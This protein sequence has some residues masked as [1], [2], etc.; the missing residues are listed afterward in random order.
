MKYDVVLMNPPFGKIISDESTKTYLKANYQNYWTDYYNLFIYRGKELS[1]YGVLGAIVPNR[2]LYAKKSAAIRELLTSKWPIRTLIEFGRD[3]MDSAA[4]D[5]MVFTVMEIEEYENPQYCFTSNLTN[6]DPELRSNELI[7]WVKSPRPIIR[8]DYFSEIQG[9]PLAYNAPSD[10]LKLFKS[11]RSLEPIYATVATGGKTFNDERFLRLRWEVQPETLSDSWIS[12]DTGGDYQPFVSPSPFTQLWK[13]DGYEVRNFGIQRHGT[14]AQVMQSSKFWFHSAL[15]YPLTSSIGF[16]PRV[17]PEMTIL[18][19]DSIGIIP[20]DDN[21][22]AKLSLLGLLNSSWAEEILTCFGEHRRNENSTVKN[23]PVFLDDEDLENKLA[24]LALKCIKEILIWETH[25][26]ESAIFVSPMFENEIPNISKSL[27]ELITK[28][29]SIAYKGFH[30]S[31]KYKQTQNNVSRI[32]AFIKPSIPSERVVDL[33]S[34]YFGCIFGRW[35]ILYSIGNKPMPNLPDPFTTLPICPPG[36]LQN[37]KGLPASP[38]DV[39][40]N[41]PLRISWSGILVDDEGHPEDVERRVREIIHVIWR[42]EDESIET[43]ASQILGIDSLREYFQ[44][45]THFF[46]DHLKRYSKSRRRA[47]IYWP[48]STSSN[49]YSLWLYYHRINDQILFTCVNDFVDPKVKL[50]SEEAARIRQKRNRSASDEK[51][52]ERLTDFEHELKDFRAEL[53]RVAAFW[54]PN[55]N[56]GVQITAAPLWKLFRHKPW[57]KKLKKT[58]E[59][60]EAGEYDWAHLAYSIWPERVRE[61]CKT[62]KSLAI[63]HDLEHLYVEPKASRKKKGKKQTQKENLGDE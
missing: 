36:M 31:P 13:N 23:M 63:A 25:K 22:V 8:L 28:L 12:V 18:S 61:K 53:L 2:L 39:P 14:D 30:I 44:K 51:E 52:L 21:D 5:A 7:N 27:E 32:S 43:G 3:V 29:D 24:H 59:K 1:Q 34:Y 58:W 9:S 4:V 42:D 19:A 60:L 57:Q 38:K 15:S 11:K 10:L 56:D 16:G 47:P 46:A 41:Y 49:S 6:L 37:T 33:L 48:L 35:D 17:F 20:N 55:L 45:P 54:K 62:D 50:V 26:E 40:I